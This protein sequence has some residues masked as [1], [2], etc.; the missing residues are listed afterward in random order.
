LKHQEIT[1][2]SNFHH[3]HD[4]TYEGIS[5]YEAFRDDLVLMYFASMEPE[6]G[7]LIRLEM[8]PLQIRNCRLRRALRQDCR[9]LRDVLDREGS[10]LGTRVELDDAMTLILKWA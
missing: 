4:A 6:S 1:P 2:P 9:W 10:S 8:R 3:F 7:K 5:G